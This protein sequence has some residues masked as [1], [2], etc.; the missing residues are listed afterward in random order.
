MKTLKVALAA[1]IGLLFVGISPAS[2]AHKD[3]GTS[4]YAADLAELNDSGATGVA[5]VEVKGNRLTV[6]IEATGLEPGEVHPQHIHGFV[7]PDNAVCPPEAAADDDPN[8]DPALISVAE[9]LPFYGAIQLPLEPFPT[10]DADGNVSFNQTFKIT[11]QQVRDLRDLGDEAIVLHGLDVDG[12]Y[13]P[14]RPVACGQLSP[15][16][17]S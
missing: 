9:G 8:D 6:N 4:F 11:G 17:Q 15:V 3:Q 2:A 14:T 12:E 7:G 5:T 1:T 10:A 13:Q 16:P